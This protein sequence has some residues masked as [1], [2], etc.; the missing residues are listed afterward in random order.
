MHDGATLVCD[1][2]VVYA[3]LN[4]RDR[5]HVACIELLSSSPSTTI[6]APVIVE[7]DW[8]SRSRGIPQATEELLMSIEDESLSVVDLDPEDY[9][10]VRSLLRA[11]A[12]IGLEFVDADPGCNPRSTPLLGRQA[13]AL[14]GVHAR[15]LDWPGCRSRSPSPS[16][17]AGPSG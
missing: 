14:R 1:A 8:L 4:P 15:S 11:S 7:I 2:S 17:R 3:A 6:P 5:S 10:R 13:S 16:G 9:A 12:D